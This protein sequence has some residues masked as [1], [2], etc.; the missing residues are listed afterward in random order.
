MT[1]CL[2][3]FMND[4]IFVIFVK[5]FVS[6]WASWLNCWL[7][8]SASLA[9]FKWGLGFHLNWFLCCF[10][11]P[12]WTHSSSSWSW[13]SCRRH[14]SFGFLLIWWNNWVINNS[15]WRVRIFNWRR[16][17]GFIFHN[18]HLNWALIGWNSCSCNIINSSIKQVLCVLSKILVSITKSRNA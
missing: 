15:K 17:G 12:G 3:L 13:P 7:C 6:K 9:W 2:T 1:I 14:I 5:C 8:V 16:D 10:R 11:L 4:M 18:S